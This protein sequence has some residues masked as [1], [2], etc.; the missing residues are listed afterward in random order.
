MGVPSF[1]RWLSEKYPCTVKPAIE[2]K[3]SD[4]GNGVEIPVD[5]LKENPNKIEFDNLYLDM[6]GLIHPCCHPE[7][8]VCRLTRRHL[9]LIKLILFN[10]ALC[11]TVPPGRVGLTFSFGPLLPALSSHSCF[12]LACSQ[13]RGGDDFS[14]LSLH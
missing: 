2:E 8:G 7:T 3:P 12:C 4:F 5:L 13:V 11:V 14:R 6:N 1:F 10:T 9:A